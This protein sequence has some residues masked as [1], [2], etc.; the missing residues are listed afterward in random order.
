MKIEK[1]LF[2]TKFDELWFDALQ[3]L[4]D[5][6]KAGLSHVVF[7]HVIERDRVAM[8]RGV[9]Y[10][11]TEE[12]KLKEM[13]NVR[14]IDWAENLFEQGMEVGAHIVV[15]TTVKKI[16]SIASDESVDLIVVGYQKKGK[17]KD[18]YAGSESMEILRRSTIPVLV[19]KYMIESGKINDKP[20]ERPLLAIDL[21][22]VS[23]RVVRFLL[24]MKE[25][26]KKIQVIHVASEK[27]F[28]G[29][30]AMDVQKIRKE[31]R[32]KMEEVCEIFRA[33][34]VDAEQHLYIG[35]VF[36][37]IEKAAHERQSTMIVGG[38]TGKGPWKERWLGSIPRKLCEQSAFPTL[39][40]HPERDIDAEGS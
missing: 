5:L 35:D 39:F 7:L 34:G 6:R 36:E 14:F 4:M 23:K 3:S 15:G 25:I 19:Y 8:H 1:I 28:E 29:S 31:N 40:I 30:S 22:P 18:I 37:Q 20:F 24:S 11:K 38:A 16:V 12:V 26:I 33:E 13:A 17:V 27:S 10:V 32:Q 2:V 21:F 9:G